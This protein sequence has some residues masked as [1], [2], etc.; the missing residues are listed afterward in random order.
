MGASGRSIL[1]ILQ[2]YLKDEHENKK[3]SPLPNSEAWKLISPK[4]SVP[5]QQNCSDCGVFMCQFLNYLSV[6]DAFD[7]SQKHM[8]NFRMKMCL[9]IINKQLFD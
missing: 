1:E 3:K 6:D 2:R 9:E 5:Q 4:R 7:F 8:Q